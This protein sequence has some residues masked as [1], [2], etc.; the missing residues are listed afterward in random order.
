MTDHSKD[1]TDQYCSRWCQDPQFWPEQDKLTLHQEKRNEVWPTYETSLRVN[2][3][4]SHHQVRQ[5]GRSQSWTCPMDNDQRIPGS[6]LLRYCH[7][8]YDTVHF[9][10]LCAIQSYLAIITR[11]IISAWPT[12]PDL[13]QICRSLIH[14]TLIWDPGHRRGTPDGFHLHILDCYWP[15]KKPSDHLLAKRNRLLDQRSLPLLDTIHLHTHLIANLHQLDLSNCRYYHL[16]DS[17]HHL[18][19]PLHN[20]IHHPVQCGERLPLLRP[21]YRAKRSNHFNHLNRL[22][23]SYLPLGFIGFLRITVRFHM[24]T[25]RLLSAF[26]R[27]HRSTSMNDLRSY[28]FYLRNIG[29]LPSCARRSRLR[30]LRHS[31]QFR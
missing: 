26:E 23:Y 28:R 21:P 20:T 22:D 30:P 18:S 16:H 15:Q 14:W 27:V 9:V 17:S 3:Q 29:T 4:K 12:N 10:G 25:L 7:Q 19:H 5:S 8:L 11:E 13:R 6:W 31:A 2:D 1:I 24:G